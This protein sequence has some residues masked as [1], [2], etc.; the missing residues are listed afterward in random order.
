MITTMVI[1]FAIGWIGSGLAL[2]KKVSWPQFIVG[3]TWLA[4]VFTAAAKAV[5]LP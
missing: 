2:E 5:D 4:V 1:G 3:G